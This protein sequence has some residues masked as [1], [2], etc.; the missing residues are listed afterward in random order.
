MASLAGYGSRRINQEKRMVYNVTDDV[1]HIAR[2]RYYYW[3]N[4]AFV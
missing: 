2:L 4:V 1:L 3:L